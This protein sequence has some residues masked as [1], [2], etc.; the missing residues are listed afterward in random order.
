[1][2]SERERVEAFWNATHTG[3]SPDHGNYLG[4][5]LV[6][7]YTAIRATGLIV[8]QLDLVIAELRDRSP[9][10]ARVLSPGCGAGHKELA[11]ARALPNRH[12]V[13]TDI[14]ESALAVGRRAAA[15]LGL[16][17]I[18][19]QTADFNHIQLERDSFDAIVGLGAF[20]HIENF[21]GFWAEC[22]RGLRKGGVIL[23]QEYVGPS[24]FQWTDA[25]IEHGDRVLREIV[26]MQHKVDHER[27]RRVPLER[28]I[29]ID[30]SEAVRSSEMLPTLKEAG[31]EL[32][33]LVSGGGALLQPVLMDQIH[34]YDPTDWQHNLVLA[35]LFAEEDRLMREGVLQDDFAMFR[36]VPV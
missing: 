19:F 9:L 23:G 3:Q 28:I 31:F 13:A 22:R 10:G 17:N 5:P 36:T 4:H 1:M 32:F 29:A 12:F 30:P 6:A 20:H 8:G 26:P 25:Q 16:T 24:R 21:E 33:A 27:V 14:A 35:K 18:E 34:T 2:T 11:L 15:Q 7:A